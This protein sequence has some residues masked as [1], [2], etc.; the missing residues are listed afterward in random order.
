MKEDAGGQPNRPP[1]LILEQLK[2]HYPVRT[3]L[4]Q[5]SANVLK[6]VD[7]VDLVIR[8]G[9]TLGLVGES[10]CG[11]STLGRLLVGL[12]QPTSGNIWFEDRQVTNRKDRERLSKDIQIVFQD[13]Y[14]SLNPRLTIGSLLAEP[15]LVHRIVPRNRVEQEVDR[16]L[17][18][19][20]LP[21]NS[22][23]R[24]AHEFSG[25]QRQRIGIARALSL[26]PKLLV[27][28]EPVSA[29]DVSIQAQVLNLL[30]DLQKDLGL[31]YLF[32][33]HGLGT[34]RYISDR[35]AVMYLGRIVEIGPTESLFK[36]PKHPYT[37]ALLDAFPVP[38]P[39]K[40]QE[41]GQELQGEVPSPVNLPR[42]CRFHT[43]CPWA[44]SQCREQE[45]T[46]GP[47]GREHRAACF[48]SE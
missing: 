20:G 7:G 41:L 37:K 45:P 47:Q 21:R 30:K 22:K 4:L 18:L 10:G 44:V 11:K 36:E 9:E 42:G 24:Y 46:L 28:D 6:A 29:L 2:K 15:L 5:F 14:S 33:A 1:L 27:C 38:D 35:V 39:R 48:F 43:R 19:V 26:R 8:R 12:E 32:I 25:G 31:T 3:G 17:D 34:V 40:R 13:P 16:L 23:G